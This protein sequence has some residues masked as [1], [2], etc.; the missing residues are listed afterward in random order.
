MDSLLWNS[1][2]WLCLCIK[3]HSIQ[4]M[5]TDAVANDKDSV[6]LQQRRPLQAKLLLPRLIPAVIVVKLICNRG[7]VSVATSHTISRE[8]PIR[9]TCGIDTMICTSIDTI[10][11]PLFQRALLFRFIILLGFAAF[12]AVI[13]W[14]IQVLLLSRFEAVE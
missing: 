7:T 2:C 9:G 1:L 10:G 14:S 3:K 6:S 4:P 13:P 5:V 11:T 8:R 12:F